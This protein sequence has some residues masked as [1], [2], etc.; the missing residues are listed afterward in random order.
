MLDVDDV[1]TSKVLLKIVKVS[2]P[3]PANPRDFTAISE[4]SL[5]GDPA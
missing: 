5:V 2:K 1:V 3:G 4:V